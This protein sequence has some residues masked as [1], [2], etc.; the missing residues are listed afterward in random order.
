MNNIAQ[1]LTVKPL[2]GP[3]GGQVSGLDV[4]RLAEADVEALKAAFAEHLVLV[5]PGQALDPSELR[6][7]AGIWG[8]VSETP[9]LRYLEGH[10]GVLQLYNMGKTESITE[11]WHSDSTFVPRPPAITILCAQTLP[12][13]GGD[14]MWSNQYLAY[15]R[16]SDGMKRML[17]GVRIRFRGTRIAKAMNNS[18]EPPTALHPVVRTHPVTG[19][20]SLF[21]G[22]PGQTAMN[23]ED[24]TIEESL[25][26][27]T[28]LYQTSTAPDAIYRHH[29]SPGDLLMWDNRCTMHYAVH[30]YGDAV[31]M[32]IR[33]TI[34]GEEP[35]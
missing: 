23:F 8:Q 27:L 14:T 22:N 30:D 16:L 12:P 18:G 34:E 21:V 26:L 32:L 31:R 3:I 19:R 7:F 15:E 5:F 11:N 35:R 4:R 1:R 20:K 33:C 10:P 13:A 6:A 9:M 24:M 2:S 17:D 29:W 28:Y 25:P